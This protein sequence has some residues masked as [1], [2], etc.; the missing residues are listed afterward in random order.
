MSE[1]RDD[2]RPP[3]DGGVRF[4]DPGPFRRIQGVTAVLIVG[5]ILI[6]LTSGSRPAEV[7]YGALVGVALLVVG[8]AVAI[9]RKG[10][11]EAHPDGQTPENR[12]K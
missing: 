7:R 3:G 9:R 11:R 10:R 6:T 5:V 1:Q 12:P 8:I 2:R 4:P